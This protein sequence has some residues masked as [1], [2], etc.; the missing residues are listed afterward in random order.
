MS[1][2]FSCF[3]RQKQFIVPF[4]FIATAL[5]RQ[6]ARVRTTI[7]SFMEFARKYWYALLVNFLICLI[8]TIA[9]TEISLK[10]QFPY[11][12]DYPIF[13]YVSRMFF[14]PS[15]I[16]L[17]YDTAYINATYHTM[18]FRYL[19]SFLLAWFPFTIPDL[20]TSYYIF[21]F[22][23]FVLNVVIMQLVVHIIEVHLHRPTTKASKLLL[24][25]FSSALFQVGTFL[26]GQPVIIVAVLAL[27][28]LKKFL[29]KRDVAGSLLLAM[30]IIIKPVLYFTV[31]FVLM[32]RKSSRSKLLY[33]G[34]IALPFLMD[35]ML[36]LNFPD[37]LR[38]FLNNNFSGG[39]ERGFFST[40]VANLFYSIFM[41]DPFLSFIITTAV[42][43]FL[44]CAVTVKIQDNTKQMVF[45][46]LFGIIGFMVA[47]IQM[48]PITLLIFFPFM[49]LG[50]VACDF[51]H[52]Y[53]QTGFLHVYS[54]IINLCIDNWILNDIAVWAPYVMVANVIILCVLVVQVIDMFL[55][56][57]CL[58]SQR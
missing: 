49:Q 7:V 31:L 55:S 53:R 42:M 1:P 34:S 51:K 8:T 11:L 35:A 52:I 36:F 56:T 45:C 48:W 20:I 40:S 21:N 12:I 18:Q 38:G 6:A 57:R 23:C 43:A 26:T 22:T 3:R 29:E 30:S 13:Y 19:P 39:I 50:M 5:T 58:V 27:L 46:F 16:L 44:G 47:Q 28:S 24:F 37:L 33:M 17:I 41:A 10:H 15:E 9:T 4:G 54:I 32:S 2:G 14:N 25:I